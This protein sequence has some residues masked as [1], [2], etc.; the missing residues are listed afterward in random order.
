MFLLPHTIPLPMSLRISTRKIENRVQIG[1]FP[2]HTSSL[3]DNEGLDHLSS[4][5]RGHLFALCFFSLLH[6]AGAPQVLSRPNGMNNEIPSLTFH[7]CFFV[8]GN[9]PRLPFSSHEAGQLPPNKNF[10]FVAEI[11]L[12]LARPFSPFSSFPPPRQS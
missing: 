8:L 4:G 10:Q 12:A 11:V 9:P 2:P 1:S 3:F 6:P 7:T 5:I